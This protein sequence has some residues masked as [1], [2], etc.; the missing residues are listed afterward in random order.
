M[1]LA[2]KHSAKPSVKMTGYAPAS[3]SQ[4]LFLSSFKFVGMPVYRCARD[5]PVAM[6]LRVAVAVRAL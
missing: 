1:K 5:S 6:V 4:M 3:A 2:E